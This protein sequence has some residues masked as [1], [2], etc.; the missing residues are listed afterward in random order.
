MKLNFIEDTKNKVVVDIKGE[1]YTFLNALKDE[2]WNDKDVKVAAFRVD[3]PLL[4]VPRLIVE[5]EKTDAKDAID[6]AA[7]RLK[8]VMA[9]FGK[10]VESLAK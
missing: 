8:K 1:D 3:H 2:L 6:K 10:D 5:T 4:K 9:K 7:Q